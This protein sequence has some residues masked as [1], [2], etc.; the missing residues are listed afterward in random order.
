MESRTSAREAALKILFQMDFTNMSTEEAIANYWGHFDHEAD[1]HEYANMLVRG[2]AEHLAEVDSAIREASTNWRLERMTFID[3]NAL[4]I[5]A[6]GLLF[7]DDLPPPVVISEAI[8][9]G[10][11]F[12]SEESGA[13]INGVLDHI[14]R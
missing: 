3:R 13:F 4:R 9:L 11:R 2:I 1:Y 14:A 12:G 5:G 6:Y 7:L 8:K 10:K